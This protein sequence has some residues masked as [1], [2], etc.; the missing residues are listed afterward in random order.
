MSMRAGRATL[1]RGEH[2]EAGV[3]KTVGDSVFEVAAYRDHFSNTA[4]TALAPAGLYSDGDIL[5]DLFSTTS[6]LNAGT[7]QVSGYRASYSRKWNEHLRMG[8]AY[9]LSGMLTAERDAVVSDSAA[10]LRSILKPGKEH[11]VTAQLIAQLP[12][13]RTWLSS[14]YQWASQTPVTPPDLFNASDTRAL[15]GMN[16]TV[17]QPLPQV[18][19]LPGKFEA[20][21]EFR[22]L[23]AQGYVPLRTADGRRLFL[24]QAARSFRGGFNFVF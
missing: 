2:M 4:L 7:Y 6:T 3:Q 12:S 15:P 10:E 5:P 21:A 23:L 13:A 14:S 8:L 22:N 17:R 11:S 18:A 1:Q 24:I 16:L 19:Y 20:T 9:G